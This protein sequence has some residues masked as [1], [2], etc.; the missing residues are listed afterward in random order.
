M[1]EAIVIGGSEKASFVLD[2]KYITKIRIR[3]K[4]HTAEIWFHTCEPFQWFFHSVGAELENGKSIW[5][6]MQ[7]H[8][9]GIWKILIDTRY[10]PICIS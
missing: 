1:F 5:S 9:D 3:S 8:F 7:I 4:F 2:A 10:I 6:H